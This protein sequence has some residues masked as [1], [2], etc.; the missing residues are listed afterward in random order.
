ML[1]TFFVRYLLFVLTFIPNISSQSDYSGNHDP[2][3]RTELALETLQ[4]W[5]NTSTGLW[6]STGWWNGANIMTLIGDFAKAA[7][8]DIL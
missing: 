2:I 3:L 8:A 1:S 6:E 7:P 5:Y 4:D